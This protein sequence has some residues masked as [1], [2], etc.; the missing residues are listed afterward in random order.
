MELITLYATR[1]RKSPYNIQ[2]ILR[3]KDGKV[4][5]VFSSMLKQPRKG[6]KTLIINCFRYKINWDN[7]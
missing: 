4:K 6:T 2:T 3:Y 7:V 1:E 5:A